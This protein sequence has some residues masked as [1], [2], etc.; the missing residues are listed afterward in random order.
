MTTLSVNGRA[1][2]AAKREPG[3]A[4]VDSTRRCV[5]ADG[6]ALGADSTIRRSPTLVF[7]RRL[8]NEIAVRKTTTEA[9]ARSRV[10]KRRMTLPSPQAPLAARV[11]AADP[12]GVAFQTK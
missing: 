11:D 7:E 5:G 8:T 9:T 1:G 6:G 3:T 4:A 12:P 2:R 10:P